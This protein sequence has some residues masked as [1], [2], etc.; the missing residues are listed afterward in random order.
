MS[1]LDRRQFIQ[2]A[3]N[4]N[5]QPSPSGIRAKASTT[6]NSILKCFAGVGGKSEIL[7]SKGGLK[8]MLESE[9]ESDLAVLSAI[10]QLNVE[11]YV[12]VFVSVTI[13]SF[14]PSQ[15]LCQHFVCHP[16]IIIIY[17]YNGSKFSTH[18]DTTAAI[19]PA[20]L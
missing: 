17:K 11:R 9:T 18:T 3:E 5:N 20:V 4:E 13:L 14:T 2:L 12:N 7:V 6:W 15:S 16:G 10:R 8:P 1:L 19:L